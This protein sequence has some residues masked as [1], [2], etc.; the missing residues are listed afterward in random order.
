MSRA[1]VKKLLVLS[2]AAFAVAAGT[3]HAQSPSTFE[4][5]LDSSLTNH[6]AIL[7]KRS[8]QAAAYADKEGAKWAR[9]PTPSFEASAPTDAGTNNSVLRIDQPLWAGGRIT[10]GIDAAASRYDAATSGLDEA[11]LD[12]TLRVIAAYVEALRQKDREQYAA[13]GVAQ[14][15]KLL[16]MIRRRV[17]KE[18]S[19][20]IDQRL[21]ETRLYQMSNDL[22]LISQALKNAFTQLSQLS[23]A[24]VGDVSWQG[25]DDTGGAASLEAALESAIAESPKLQRLRHEE[26]AALADIDSRRSVYMPQLTLRMQR[27]MGGGA[28]PDNRM[29]VVL[30]AQPGAGLS[31]GTGVEAAV[32]RREAVRQAQE[33]AERDVRER[34]TLDWNEWLAARSR[35]E[36]ARRSSAISDEVFESYTRQY[37]IG[38]KTWIDVLNAVRETVQANFTLADARAQTVAAGLRLKAQTRGLKLK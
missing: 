23:G 22:S 35:L 11:R 8:E 12:M 37:V 34:V 6:P 31:A 16:A 21:A 29:M 14:H 25:V 26:Q 20:Q 18:V 13:A 33:T 17:D 5:V 3:G 19:S 27:S 24:A 15:E 30:Q 38:R 4:H 2:L 10:A 32:A 1:A 36:A 9:F 28:A 7:G